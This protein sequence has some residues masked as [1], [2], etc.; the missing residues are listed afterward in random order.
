MLDIHQV[1]VYKWIPHP[2]TVYGV[3][4]YIFTH[5]G[6]NGYETINYNEPVVG[7]EMMWVH[8]IEPTAA[9]L[10]HYIISCVMFVVEELK[11]N[12]LL[13]SL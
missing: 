11:L 2:P 1:N 7:E 3:Y 9:I 12:L 5:T 10:H 6:Y 8:P 13:T 4:E